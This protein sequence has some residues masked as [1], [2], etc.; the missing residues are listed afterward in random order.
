MGV[1]CLPAT[2]TSS[3]NRPEAANAIR[4]SN[5]DKGSRQAIRDKRSGTSDPGQG[6]KP[7]DQARD[8]AWARWCG[9]LK[10]I[11]QYLRAARPSIA[12]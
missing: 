10:R 5:Q 7:R 6:I 4:P 11:H 12:C 9:P 1:G 2:P 3:P 8:Q